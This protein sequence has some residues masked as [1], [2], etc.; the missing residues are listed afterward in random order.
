[1]KGHNHKEMG[2]MRGKIETKEIKR[3][4]RDGN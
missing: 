2:K 4:K 3:K 1:M